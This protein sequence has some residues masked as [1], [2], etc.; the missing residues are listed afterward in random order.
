MNHFNDKYRFKN[1]H[2]TRWVNGAGNRAALLRA[3]RTS[4]VE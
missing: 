3:C 1:S 4:S 2:L